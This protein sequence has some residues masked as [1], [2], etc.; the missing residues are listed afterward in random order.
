MRLKLNHSKNYKLQTTL[1]YLLTYGWA[2]FIIIIVIGSFILLGLI[3]YYAILFGLNLLNSTSSVWKV[4][5]IIIL[6]IGACILV[7]IPSTILNYILKYKIRK[8]WSN[9]KK[10]WSDIDIILQKRHNMLRKLIDSVS[11][12][13]KNEN[14]VMMQITQL[15]SI[16]ALIPQD[17]VQFKINT[18]NQISAA[19]KS[20][21]AVAE[22]YPDLK[23]D[24]NFIQLKQSITELETELADK[25]EEYNNNV[26]IFNKKIQRFPSNMVVRSIAR[27]CKYYTAQ[28]LFPVPEEEKQDVK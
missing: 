26:N 2:I 19:L 12:Y 28:P 18:S 25:R 27:V 22:N 11:G 16:W 17:D 7:S 4:I 9:V 13:I 8:S 3:I 24:N 10:S 14:G 21:F 15:R 20:I 6:G 23:A 5:G 1:E